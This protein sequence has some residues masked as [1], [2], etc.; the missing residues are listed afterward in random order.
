M[1]DSDSCRVTVFP[2][3]FLT[4]KASTSSVNDVCA[5]ADRGMGALL[6]LT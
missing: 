6:V 2:E 1:P 5:H 4:D 3:S